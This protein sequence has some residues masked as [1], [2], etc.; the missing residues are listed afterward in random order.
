MNLRLAGGTAVVGRAS[1]FLNT[2]AC[3]T[4][5]L[6]IHLVVT[7]AQTSLRKPSRAKQELTNL[8]VTP[9]GGQGVALTDFAVTCASTSST[10]RSRRMARS[11]KSPLLEECC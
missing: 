1:G 9:G 7:L 8:S 2:E 11:F 10:S 6:A 5:G 4:H 3:T